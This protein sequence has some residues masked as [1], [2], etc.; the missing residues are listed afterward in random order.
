[1]QWS[2][3]QAPSKSRGPR[4]GPTGSIPPTGSPN[5]PKHYST[6][7]GF[8]AWRPRN[9]FLSAAADYSSWVGTPTESPNP[10]VK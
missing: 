4:P 10:L 6:D 9:W 8:A 7:L 1:M 5:F 3:A 2:A